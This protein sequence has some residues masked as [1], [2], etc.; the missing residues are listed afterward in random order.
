L[1]AGGD[2][3]MAP[4]DDDL[5]E[6]E[7]LRRQ[8]VQA[9]Q[10]LT[11]LRRLHE[12]TLAELVQVSDDMDN[13]LSSTDVYTLFLDENLAIRK[14]TP[15]FGELIPISENDLGR[16]VEWFAKFFP[17][18]NLVGKLTETLDSHRTIDEEFAMGGRC[19]QFRILPCRGHWWRRGVLLTLRDI[20]ESKEAETRFRSTF[21]VA[22]VGIAHISLEGYW[23]KVNDRLC[24][25]VGYSSSEMVLKQFSEL[26]HPDD[27]L[28]DSEKYSDLMA[29]KIER[30]TTE[31]RFI[32]KDSQTVWVSISISLQRNVGGAPQY[33][34]AIIQDISE[35]KR[36]EQGLT[37]AVEQRDR[38]L[39]TLSHELRNPLASVRHALHVFQHE[40]STVQQRTTALRTVER[41]TEHMSYLLDDLLDVSRITQG[42]IA[43]DMRSIDMCRVV[44][45]CVDAMI[46][47]FEKRL[48]HLEIEIPSQPVVVRGDESRLLQVI[49]NLLTNACKYTDPGGSIKLILSVQDAHCVLKVEDNGRGIESDLVDNV[50]DMFVQSENELSRR[51]GGMGLGLT[52]ARSLVQHHQGT[53]L[54]NS[55]GLGHGSTFTVTLPLSNSPLSDD[56]PATSLTQKNK[57]PLSSMPIVL[58]EDND[59]SRE[60]LSDYLELEG[61]VVKS[62]ASGRDGLRLLVALTPSLALVDLGLP[63]LDGFAVAREFRKQCPDADTYLISL[64]GYGQTSDIIASEAAGFNQHL[65][66]PIAPAELVEILKSLSKPRID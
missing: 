63:E 24:E 22:A 6:T 8:L 49:E 31:K 14:F 15:Q 44:Q 46:Q 11:T 65:I 54:A 51:E 53:I 50:F 9:E 30:F 33:A 41:Q 57:S 61:F 26:I 62:C 12:S 56:L 29:G 58:I 35:R 25:D 55:P 48:H 60:M 64:S 43:Y 39:A 18:E 2:E 16:K 28:V 21:D 45:D 59:D 37:E 1:I 32:R 36:F 40:R 10:K 34:I 38:F 5:D 27:L 52:V 3:T 66:K 17:C 13:L 20:T 19:Y 47:E 7:S 23:F 4:Q 42:K